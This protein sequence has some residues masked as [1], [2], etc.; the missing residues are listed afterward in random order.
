MNYNPITCKINKKLQIK[1]KPKINIKFS[2]AI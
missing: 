2:S 1:K